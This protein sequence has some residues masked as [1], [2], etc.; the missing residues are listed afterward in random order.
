MSFQKITN[1][2]LTE[3]F[4]QQIEN[5]IISGELKVGEKL[6]SARELCENLG[7]SRSVVSAG[8]VE[9]AKL[10]F[11]EIRTRQ[12]VYVGDYLRKGTVETMAAIMHYQNGMMRKN[13][14]ISLLQVRDVLERL[15]IM[16][17]IANSA[18]EDIKKLE[19]L[20]EAI[21]VTNPEQAAMAIFTF[22]HELAVVSG[23]VLLPLMYHSFKPQSVY[24]WV[25]SCKNIGTQ[26]HYEHKKQMYRA[27]INRDKEEAERVLGEGI[28]FATNQMRDLLQR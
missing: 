1:M 13:E 20:V 17:V 3:L 10:G 11:V 28:S 21:N 16:L 18:T 27:I 7:V 6:P 22:H 14:V 2:S 4:V 19:P 23:N 9:L 5:M 12:G 15:C 25:M 26:I 24:L 8:M